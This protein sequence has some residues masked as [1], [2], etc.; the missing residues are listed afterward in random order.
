M[1]NDG[2]TL[3]NLLSGGDTSGE[4]TEEAKR[5]IEQHLD[6]G[7][8]LEFEIHGKGT[9]TREVDGEVTDI[10]QGDG[11]S[12]LAVT[13]RQV[14]LVVYTPHDETVIDAHYTD[15]R[16][17]ELDS[18]FLKTTL[19]L[20]VWD[21]GSYRFRPRSKDTAQ[22][23]VE[24]VDA[25][26][27]AW[28]FS[29]T[30]L[31]ELEGQTTTV[32]SHIEAGRLDQAESVLED[33]HVTM[34]ELEGRIE[35]AD[36]GDVFADRARQAEGE[37]HRT[38]IHAHLSRAKT[39]TTEAKHQTD[40]TNYTGAYQR[41]ERAKAH[42]ERAQAIAAEHGFDDP[43]RATAELGHID[44]RMKNLEVRPMALAKQATERAL[45]TNHADEEVDA[46]ADALEHY[47]DALT[48]GWGTSFDTAGDPQELRDLAEGAVDNLIQAHKDYAAELE[49]KAEED[50]DR[51]NVESARDHYETAIEHVEAAHDLSREFR[52]GDSDA[53]AE[54]KR[55]L[56]WNL[57]AL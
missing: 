48:T 54:Q 7:E 37:L 10:G 32:G 11:N 6:A 46:W 40:A 13:D 34:A 5:A 47:R 20:D 38:R 45:G 23:A 27:D 51:G 26:S 8:E 42:I 18:S 41:Y 16:N 53:I 15:V 56:E 21:D 25:I 1:T 50:T 14:L 19:V 35:A 39:L 28:Q 3:R 9:V 31:D 17:I 49:M 24:Y 4:L 43:P 55:W 44:S 33:A 29:E 12:L 36:L 30:L 52:S 2:G 57:E 22:E